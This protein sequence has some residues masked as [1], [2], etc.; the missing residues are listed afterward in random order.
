MAEKKELVQFAIVNNT[1]CD[2]NIPLMQRNVYS[3]NATT[4]YSWNVTTSSL[5]CLTGTIV[6]NGQTVSFTFTQAT[7]AAVLAALNAL[8]YGFFCS[9]TIG[10]D[11]FIYCN[12]DTNVYGLLT[13]CPVTTSTTTTTTTAAPVT[14]S[15]TTT[16]TT[17]APVTTSTTTTT[18]TAP[19]TTSTTTTTTTL[20]DCTLAGTAEVT[21]AP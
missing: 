15:T 10:P 4:K 8:G 20:A 19:I 18:T 11:T 21:A 7:L 1:G 5:L 14:T 17:A 3:I 2:F 12:D 6:V 16:T 9:Q 13:L